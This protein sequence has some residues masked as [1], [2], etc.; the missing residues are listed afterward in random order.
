MGIGFGVLWDWCI[1]DL[2]GM[3]NMRKGYKVEDLSGFG[4]L[5]KAFLMLI[6]V[7]IRFLSNHI[8][9]K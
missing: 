6:H 8:I 1:F 4:L 7:Y 9:F 5:L 3:D 2:G